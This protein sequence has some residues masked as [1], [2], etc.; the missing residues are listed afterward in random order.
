MPL[1]A[2]VVD[3]KVA[4][5]HEHDKS[6]LVMAK[7]LPLLAG[8]ALV[9]AWYGAMG[10][11]LV[12]GNEDRVLQLFEPALSVP[13]RLRLCPDGDGCQLVSLFFAEA[14]FASSAATGADSFWT[15]VEHVAKLSAFAAAVAGGASVPKL[16]AV[17]RNYGL[18][19]KG[20]AITEANVKA[21]E[22]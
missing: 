18:T 6:A 4:Q 15:F 9:I 19:F 13:I 21:L 7:P 20:K 3:A 12:H 1:P 11:A 17:V 22:I 8:R 5:R 10:E 2:S 16:A 14:L